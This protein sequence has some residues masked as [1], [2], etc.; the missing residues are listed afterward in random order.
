MK[1]LYKPMVRPKD[2]GL[3]KQVVE[4]P[5]LKS[6]MENPKEEITGLVI[7]DRKKLKLYDFETQETETLIQKL[8]GGT[9]DALEYHDETLW[10]GTSGAFKGWIYSLKEK[11]RSKRS[12]SIKFFLSHNGVLFDGGNYGLRETISGEYH[13]KKEELEDKNIDSILGCFFHEGRFLALGRK[14]ESGDERYITF[15]EMDMDENKVSL[16]NNY[17]KRMAFHNFKHCAISVGGNIITTLPKKFLDI[18]GCLLDVTRIDRGQYNQV[19]FDPGRE[20][21]YASGGDIYSIKA[22]Q[23]KNE[24]GKTSFTSKGDLVDELSDWVTFLPVTKEQMEV[25]REQAK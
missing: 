21:I 17:L 10:I 1:D 22:F 8:R 24:D 13:I 15:Y 6:E 7:G 25:I 19:V 4:E 23:V 5:D 12:D 16:T 14:S 2:G 9:V 18:E 3:E 20:Q 11:K